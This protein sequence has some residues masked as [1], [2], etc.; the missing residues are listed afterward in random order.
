LISYYDVFR[1]RAGQVN[2]LNPWTDAQIDTYLDQAA[3]K[4]SRAFATPWS[5]FSDVS[6][7]YKWPLTIMAAIEYWYGQA[8][9]YV[10]KSDI[11]AGSGGIGK[12]ST[13]LFDKALR[14]ISF[15]QDE[16]EEYAD[17][18]P[19]EGS[20]DVFVGTLVKRSKF[21]GYLVPRAADPRGDW[22]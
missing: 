13:T 16:L 21:S 22:F 19:V 20:G 7:V 1:Q 18:L 3:V 14:M 11:K 8:A 12:V 17:S 4:Q 2:T 10:D 9:S 5:D 6:E 15:L